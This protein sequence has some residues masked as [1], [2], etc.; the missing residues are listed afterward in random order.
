M[1]FPKMHAKSRTIRSVISALFVCFLA[2]GI[3]SGQEYKSQEI[4]D[5]NGIPVL[6]LHLPEWETAKDRALLTNELAKTVPVVG[7][8]PILS[9]VELLPG[10]EAA[11]AEYPAGKLLLIEHPSPQAATAADQAVLATG[12]EFIYRRIGNYSA[13]VFDVNDAAAANGL[14]DQIKYEKTVQWL[15]EDP[16]LLQKIERYIATTGAE[17]AVSTVLFIGIVVG[18]ALT[19]GIITG[20]VYFRFRENQRA[21]QAAFSDAGGLTRINLDELSEP[22]QLDPN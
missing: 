18:L 6:I 7:D 3:V 21:G 17:V 13:F 4:S 22:L 15:G 8:Q 19:L 20:I 2:I 12:G 9:K 14:L 16:F 11:A 1:I 10:G 5:G